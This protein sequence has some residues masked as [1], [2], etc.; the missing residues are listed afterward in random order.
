M[1][2]CFAHRSSDLS[3]R[4]YLMSSVSLTRQN[5]RNSTFQVEA[6]WKDTSESPRPEAYSRQNDGWRRLSDVNVLHSVINSSWS[7]AA[8]WFWPMPELQIE[9]GQ[10]TLG[11]ALF[12]LLAVGCTIPSTYWFPDFVDFP[13]FQTLLNGR[14]TLSTYSLMVS[15][16]ARTFDLPD[17]CPI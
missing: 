17:E 6:T 16:S 4:Y 5:C 13:T 10:P 3:F 7:P 2:L 14:F 11:Y 15:F 12:L 8:K 9:Y 1:Y